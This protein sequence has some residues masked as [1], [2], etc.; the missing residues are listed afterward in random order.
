[1]V[2]YDSLKTD[3]LAIFEV[4]SQYEIKQAESSFKAYPVI[5]CIT[6]IIMFA[7]QEEND[8]HIHLI[9]LRAY[10]LNKKG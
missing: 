4:P 3:G 1:M 5:Y 8:L 10:K 9:F 2:E 6:I 7:L